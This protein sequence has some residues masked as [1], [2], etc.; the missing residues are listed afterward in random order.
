MGRLRL[1]V[2]L[3]AG[4]AVAAPAGAGTG[5]EVPGVI[6]KAEQLRGLRATHPLAVSNVDADGMRRVVLHELAAEREAVPDAAWNDALHLLGVLR[7]GQS[8]A[9]IQ[10]TELTGQVAGIY[11]PRGAR[12]Y[13]LASGSSAPRSVIAHEVVHALQDE[14]FRLTRGAFAARPLDHD[15]E[16]AAQALVEGDATE[17]QSRY[18]ASLSAGD[19][20]GELGRTLGAMPA[21]AA[22]T[23]TVPYLQRQLLFP[24]TAGEEFVRALRARGGQ[25]LLD[26]AFRHPPRTTAAVLDPARYLAG[27]PPP[28]SV[29]LPGLRY[30]L[31]TT[32]GAEDLAALTGAPALARGWLGG[33]LGIGQGGLDLRI[34]TSR[35]A[36][37]AAALRRTLP[38]RAAVAFR[39]RLVC[40][41]IVRTSALV[42]A[43]S[44]R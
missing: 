21:D 22:G 35:A 39:G 8:L 11:V 27:D 28:Q 36:A 15:G 9:A 3:V 1:L 38:A 40:V 2:V 30:R 37:V 12:L 5:S 29:H 26:R 44:C 23:G 6:A 31:A 13:V 19:L 42:Q 24:Y 33:R 18:I 16:L 41:R 25:R 17:V 32:F 4:L 43:L 14:H 34:A 7:S 20:I 10:R